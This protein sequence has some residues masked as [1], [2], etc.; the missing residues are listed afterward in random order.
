MDE[1]K[2]LPVGSIAPAPP[3]PFPFI[4]NLAQLGLDPGRHHAAFP[5]L[6]VDLDA[7]T[8]RV[9]TLGVEAI[10]TRS[11]ECAAVIFGP[12]FRKAD[13][14]VYGDAALFLGEG[15]AFMEDATPEGQGL[16]VVSCSA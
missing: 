5:Q 1:C 2:P 9:E 8:I 6:Y 14:G 12:L 10:S 11:P 13:S 7:D 3:T 16:T 15:L 4:G